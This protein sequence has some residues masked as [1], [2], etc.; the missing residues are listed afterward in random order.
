MF[1]H[2]LFHDLDAFRDFP[3]CRHKLARQGEALG[4]CRHP[5]LDLV[6][7][8]PAQIDRFQSLHPPAIGNPPHEDETADKK[9]HQGPLQPVDHSGL[10]WLDGWFA[11]PAAV[12][13]I[14]SALTSFR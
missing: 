8:V 7:Q 3:F 14:R 5:A 4:I 2:R 1:R 9:A 10:A 6:T 12:N 11:A 13:A